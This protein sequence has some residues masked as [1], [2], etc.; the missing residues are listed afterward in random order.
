[1][2]YSSANRDPATFGPT[3][4]EFRIDRDPNHHVAFGFGAHFCLGATL[5]RLEARIALEELLALDV[6]LQPAGDVVRSSS[7][8]IAGVQ[9]APLVLQ[10]C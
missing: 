5:A 7:T 8:V 9:R 6:D 4:E 2:L 10:P 3:A 1:M